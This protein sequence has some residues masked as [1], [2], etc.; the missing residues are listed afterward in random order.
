M[1]EPTNK[2]QLCRKWSE[3][4]V[5]T[6]LPYFMANWSAKTAPPHNTEGLPNDIAAKVANGDIPV[7]MFG[8]NEEESEIRRTG[9]LV[10]RKVYDAVAAKLET[11]I[12]E[13]SK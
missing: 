3:D 12:E 7:R 11:M 1:T 13:I 2:K 5:K 8:V 9:V 10:S 6:V 4:I